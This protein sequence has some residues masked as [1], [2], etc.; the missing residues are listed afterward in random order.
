MS[1]ANKSSHFVKGDSR[2][3]TG[4]LRIL[5][6]DPGSRITGFGILEVHKQE[7]VCITGG[8]LRLS[9]ETVSEKLG[10]LL[11]HL[12]DLIQTYAPTQMAIEAIFVHKNV[13]S[14]LKLA[15]ARG[16]ALA[17]AMTKQLPVFEYAARQVKLAVVGKGN[18][19]K[20]QVQHMVKQILKLDSIP[21]ADAADALAIALCHA[22]VQTGWG[23]MIE[24]Q[25]P[26]VFSR[27]RGLKKRNY[28]WPG[29]I[30]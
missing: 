25:G 12:Q 27:K 2:V 1:E 8:C 30:E 13:N 11:K 22:Q 21:Q 16:V 29:M 20:T 4:G 15:Q 26:G 14:A 17:A 19:D 7:M 10:E 23:V 28:K 6:I 9:G 5:G 24:G 3:A 18:A